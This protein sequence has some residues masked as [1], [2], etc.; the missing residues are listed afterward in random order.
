MHRQIRALLDAGHQVTYAA[1]FTARGV[2]PWETLSALDLP[3]GRSSARWQ[4]SKAAGTIVRRHA[5]AADVILV[6]DLELLLSLR[7]LQ[8]P[9]VVWD[10]HEYATG[11]AW[12]WLPTA[13]RPAARM[14]TGVAER[15]AE[16][17]VHLLL[18]S[19]GH[20][21]QCR[22]AHPVIRDVPLVQEIVP[23]PTQPRAVYLGPLTVDRGLH[24]LI[25][26]GERLAGIVD[27]E[28]TGPA[29]GRARDALYAA[30]DA[31]HLRWLGQLPYDVALRRMEGAAAGLSLLHDSARLV[32]AEPVEAL[33]YMACGVPVV[34]TPL[35]Q[36][37]ALIETQRCGLVVP[38]HD[39]AAAARAVLRLYDD[40]YL[41][42]AMGARGHAAALASHDWANESTRF[43]RRLESWASA[44]LRV[45]HVSRQ[46]AAATS[47]T[48]P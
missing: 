26:T 16:Q 19:A 5:D 2:T 17:N 6:H 18:P 23:R 14:A 7:D 28:V 38:F 9:C 40:E 11:S 31:G 20:R 3:R 32:A 4:A 10:V 12:S 29:D 33:D 15:W 30:H 43:V 47:R 13:L 41:A 39:A 22:Q 21:E 45:S 8:H 25:E 34:S 42:N 27:V 35:P 1:P 46:H 37:A 48:G 36:P 44:E 24:E